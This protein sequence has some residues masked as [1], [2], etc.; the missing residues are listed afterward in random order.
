LTRSFVIGVIGA[1]FGLEGFVKVSSPSGEFSHLEKLKSVRLRKG[2]TETV[3]TVGETALSGGGLL[4]KFAGIDSPEAVKPWK[5]AEILGGRED[6]AP[7]GP[8][9][10]YIE[11][12]K[13]L[14][15]ETPEGEVLG[16]LADILEGGGGELAEI[17]LPT[18]KTALAPFRKE[19]FGEI[20]PE[21]GRVILREKWVIG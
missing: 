1:P 17:R 13:G 20:S 3:L 12:L 16:V 6:A 18:G 15:V 8:G 2:G 4:M 11:D 9:E 7:L 10:F 21:K 5:G 14:R 19:F